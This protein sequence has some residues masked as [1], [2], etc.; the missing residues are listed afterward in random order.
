MDERTSPIPQPGG[1]S[2]GENPEKSSGEASIFSNFSE[3]QQLF[4]DIERFPAGPADKPPARSSAPNGLRRLSC[5]GF[6]EVRTEGSAGYSTV[7][8]PAET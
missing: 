5:K 4:L 6:G 3:L 8:P 1:K 7:N 2:A